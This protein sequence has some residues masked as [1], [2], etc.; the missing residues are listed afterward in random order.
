MNQA[1]ACLASWTGILHPPNRSRPSG[2]CE[3]V[4]YHMRSSVR[5]RYQLAGWLAGDLTS[6]LS[7]WP[8]TANHAEHQDPHDHAY[9]ANASTY[10]QLALQCIKPGNGP[11]HSGNEDARGLVH[12]SLL[13]SWPT[14]K[15]WTFSPAALLRKINVSKLSRQN[16]INTIYPQ[17]PSIM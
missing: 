7:S 16:F 14:H 4:S 1:R 8:H 9:D 11:A 2:I 5:G 15:I 10:S 12:N 3:C 6:P 17:G 13:S